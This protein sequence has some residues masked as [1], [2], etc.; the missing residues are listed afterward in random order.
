MISAYAAYHLMDKW[1]WKYFVGNDFINSSSFFFSRS[2]ACI[3][4]FCHEREDFL[5]LKMKIDTAK[6]YGE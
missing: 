4:N 5:A 1:N 3:K 2:P 6:S